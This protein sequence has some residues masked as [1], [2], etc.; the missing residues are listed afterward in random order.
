MKRKYFYARIGSQIFK[1]D[2]TSIEFQFVE[3]VLL[4]VWPSRILV[5]KYLTI[6][7]LFATWVYNLRKSFLFLASIQLTIFKMQWSYWNEF[8]YK[9]PTK[10]PSHCPFFI[11]VIFTQWVSY[12]YCS[13]AFVFILI[14]VARN[15]FLCYRKSEVKFQKVEKTSWIQFL[16]AAVINHCAV[17]CIL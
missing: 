9:S 3:Y 5:R 11:F 6:R 15:L 8:F 12:Y 16:V 13:A 2:F 14:P 4:F 1:K 17:Y 10:T 7:H